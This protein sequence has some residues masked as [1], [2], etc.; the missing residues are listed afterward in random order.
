MHALEPRLE[1]LNVQIIRPCPLCLE[2][3]SCTT[4]SFGACTSPEPSACTMDMSSMCACPHPLAGGSSNLNGIA[5]A[6][7]LHMLLVVRVGRRSATPA[8]KATADVSQEFDGF[9]ASSRNSAP[10]SCGILWELGGGGEMSLWV[11]AEIC[12]VLVGAC[13]VLWVSCGF[14]V[15]LLR[16]FVAPQIGQICAAEIGQQIGQPAILRG[17]ITG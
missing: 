9:S 2:P 12:G 17:K 16:K 6:C 8:P 14:L 4:T 11:L 13:G 7:V 1:A 3:H 5:H 10:G 15:G